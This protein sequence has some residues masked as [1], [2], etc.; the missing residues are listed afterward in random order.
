[1]LCS[2]VRQKDLLISV[3]SEVHYI[4]VQHSLVQQQDNN[5]LYALDEQVRRYEVA[6]LVTKYEALGIPW[7]CYLMMKAF[8]A[9]LKR[10]T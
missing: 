7:C 2:T 6:G 10:K 5:L 8:A 9:V 1:M 4:T 3:V